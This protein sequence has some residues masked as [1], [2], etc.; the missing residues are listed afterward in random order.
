MGQFQALKI[1][2]GS[3]P[4]FRTAP[5]EW[6]G[7]FSAFPPSHTLPPNTLPAGKEQDTFKT[8]TVCA[9]DCL[10]DA[11]KL[12]FGLT[13]AEIIAKLDLLSPRYTGTAA[14]GHF[15]RPEFPWERT[16]QAKILRA[17]VI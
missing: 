5:A 7:R 15:G 8:G 1:Q 12:V 16:D 2:G 9:D 13:P 14:Y 3:A 11:V 10:A 4:F 6:P 17:A